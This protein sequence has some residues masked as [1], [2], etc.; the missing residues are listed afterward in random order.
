MTR[1]PH[2]YASRA[3]ATLAAAMLVAGGVHGAEGDFSLTRAKVR[4]PIGAPPPSLPALGEDASLADYLRYAAHNNPGLR[5][6]HGRWRAAMQV[7]PQAKSLPDPRLSYSYY[8]QEVETRIGPQRQRI[9][10]SQMFPWFGKLRLRSDAAARTADAAWLDLQTQRLQLLYRVSV[11]YHDL[12]TLKE[13][14]DVTRSSFD[15]LK[16][17]EAVARER[18]RTGQVLTAV[19]QAQVELGKLEDRLRSLRELR[20]PMVSKLNAALNRESDAPLP[21][22]SLPPGELPELDAETVLDQLRSQNPDLARFTALAEK[23]Q[24]S[25]E[26]A[27]KSGYPDITLGVST[28][29]TDDA[30]MSASDSGKDPVMATVSINLPIWRGKYR[31]ERREAVLRGAALLDQKKNRANDLEADTKLALYHYA[32]AGRKIDLYR[33]TLLP[34]AEQSLGVAQQAFQAGKAGFLTVIDAQ[35]ILL[36]FQLAAVKARS[37]LGK[38]FAEIQMLTGAGSLRQAPEHE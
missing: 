20:P 25:A 32:D 14:I 36:E 27:R 22:P 8:V 38:R 10:L 11:L 5:A 33:D 6:A 12:H 35:R 21:W 23:A 28:I 31:A 15:L 24:I 18:Y 13:T 16:G 1:R 17:L 2:A 4:P 3:M 7:I 30:R 26:L 34:K 37:D 29:D 19:M 9:A